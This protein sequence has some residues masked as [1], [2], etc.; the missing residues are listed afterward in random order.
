MTLLPLAQERSHGAARPHPPTPERPRCAHAPPGTLRLV[1][2]LYLFRLS[3]PLSAA[4]PV[5]APGSGLCSQ[6][7]KRALNPLALKG[8]S[9]AQRFLSCLHPGMPQALP[10]LETGAAGCSHPFLEL[11][12]KP[13]QFGEGWRL[14]GS[15]V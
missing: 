3:F 10:R 12:K 11:G 14:R 1:S 2:G 5:S 7:S 8:K 4:L 15:P 13:T 9:R 6:L